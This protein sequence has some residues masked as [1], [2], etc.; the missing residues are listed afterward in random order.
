MAAPVLARDLSLGSRGDDVRDLQRFLISHGDLPAGN[1]TGYFGPLTQ[2]AVQAFQRTQ[3]IVTSGTS[4]TTGFG[5][6]GPK[7][8]V[9]IISGTSGP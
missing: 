4:A 9:A 1:D 3:N 8:R 6:V 7:T 2:Q 5:A